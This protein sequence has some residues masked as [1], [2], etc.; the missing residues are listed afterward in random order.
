MK[1][2]LLAVTAIL[3]LAGVCDAQNISSSSVKPAANER[4][5]SQTERT[6]NF[7]AIKG[8]DT[9]EKAETR[10]FAETMATV[11]KRQQAEI[12]AAM[13]QLNSLKKKHQAELQDLAKQ[14]KAMRDRQNSEK[15][16]LMKSLYP[17]SA[18]GQ[19]TM[20]SNSMTKTAPVKAKT[21]K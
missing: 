6:K 4:K 13:E 12:Q 8:L 11:R 21:G 18:Q 19:K 5:F 2:R 9:K 7:Q 10:A 14:G 17:V 15:A 1:N 20:T 3:L 16:T